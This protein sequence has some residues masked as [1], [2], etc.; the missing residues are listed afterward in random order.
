MTRN[1]NSHAPIA[2]AIAGLAL[3]ATSAHAA[4]VQTIQV[5]GNPAAFD[6]AVTTSLTTLATASAPAP[7][8]GNTLGLSDGTASGFTVP[9]LSTS[10]T[11]YNGLNAGAATITFTL[12]QAYNITSISSLT[13]WSAGYFGS[14]IFTL[15]LETGGSGTFTQLVNPLASNP[16]G[17]GNFGTT[18]YITPGVAGFPVVIDDG[19]A[20]LTTITDDSGTIAG[21]VTAV[22]FEFSDPYSGIGSLN[23]TVIRELSIT[24]T[25][26]PEPSV[27][28]LGLFGILGS[29]RRRRH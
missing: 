16:V 5:D 22:R 20:V 24:G 17:A 26:V 7:S 15:S 8:A 29:M 27:A 9:D 18:P 28:L 25:A 12:D 10:S 23:G 13:G 6:G 2:A 14:Q 11:W 19:F 21:N 1:R 3:T 4:V